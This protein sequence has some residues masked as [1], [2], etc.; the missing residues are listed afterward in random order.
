MDSMVNLRLKNLDSICVKKLE[1][2]YMLYTDKRDMG[3]KVL[4]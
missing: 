4:L 3:A 1:G 2:N